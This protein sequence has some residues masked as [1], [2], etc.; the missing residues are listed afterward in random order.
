ME[1]E[2]CRNC[3]WYVDIICYV[4]GLEVEPSFCCE[5]YEGVEDAQDIHTS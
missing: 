1:R 5:N 3:I 4:E 2:C